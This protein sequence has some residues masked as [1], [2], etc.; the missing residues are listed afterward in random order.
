MNFTTLKARRN[1]ETRQVNDF[2]TKIVYKSGLTTVKIHKELKNFFVETFKSSHKDFNPQFNLGDI[3]ILS[4]KK[5]ISRIQTAPA[6]WNHETSA[7]GGCAWNILD[8]VSYIPSANTDGSNHIED[9]IPTEEEVK[10]G[11]QAFFE[12]LTQAKKGATLELG[13]NQCGDGDSWFFKAV[14]LSNVGWIVLEDWTEN[15]DWQE[16][17]LASF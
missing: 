5:L 16:I 17:K 4:E 2:L 8:G 13:E 14:K 1:Q 15:G 9:D 7:G 6:P 10:E 3:Q 12:A 11:F